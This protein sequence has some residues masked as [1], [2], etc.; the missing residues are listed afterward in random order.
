[1]DNTLYIKHMVCSRC[2]MV[3][4]EQLEKAGLSPIDVKLGEAIFDHALT[5]DETARAKEVLE[6]L[7]FG[8]I[9]DRK[10]I[11]TE[12]IKQTIITL[13]HQDSIDSPDGG[14]AASMNLSDYLSSKLDCDYK[15]LSTT[16]SDL[17]NT[18]IEQFCIAQKIERVKEL[19]IYGEMSLTEIADRMNYSSV[20]YLSAQF[21]RITGFS[22]SEFRKIKG[23]KRIPIEKI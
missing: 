15:Y 10:R 7:G 20:A 3:V 23:E 16:F 5:S 1:M 11:L 2:I 22:P 18:T 12:Q 19:L 13:V 14:C 17:E 4:R 9:D 6:P 21:R 8:F